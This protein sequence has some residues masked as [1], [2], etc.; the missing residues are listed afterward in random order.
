MQR[1]T[2]SLVPEVTSTSISGFGITQVL[3]QTPAPLLLI[4]GDPSLNNISEA[5]QRIHPLSLRRRIYVECHRSL[6]LEDYLHVVPTHDPICLFV[7]RFE[8]RSYPRLPERLR[9]LPPLS[10]AI[11]GVSET[12][13]RH[14]HPRKQTHQPT[15]LALEPWCVK[16]RSEP[17]AEELVVHLPGKKEKAHEQR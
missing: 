4:V 8:D 12:P 16:T 9:R 3:V 2:S 17:G 6:P 14:L 13:G 7:D 11:G 10:Y 15:Y 1:S 5:V